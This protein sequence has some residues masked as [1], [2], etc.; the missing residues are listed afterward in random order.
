[1]PSGGHKYISSIRSLLRYAA[2]ASNWWILR[3]QDAAYARQEN[4]VSQCRQENGLI[5]EPP[6]ETKLMA[7]A[8]HY[9]H[10]EICNEFG[11]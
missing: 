5:C 8:C 7:R 3:S 9:Y 10:L 11:M 6:T 1:M 2:M 4:R